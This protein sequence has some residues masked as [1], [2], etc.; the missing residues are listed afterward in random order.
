MSTTIATA[1]LD[2]RA[3]IKEILANFS[4][5]FAG[6][7]ETKTYVVGREPHATKEGY[8]NLGLAQ[9]VIT[10]GTPQNEAATFFLGFDT[11]RVLKTLQ[12]AADDIA[13]TIP[14][15]SEVPFNLELQRQITPFY[16]KRD[17]TPQDAVTNPSSGEVMH[18]W[19]QIVPVS[20]PAEHDP[21]PELTVKNSNLPD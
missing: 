12:L 21:V 19:E 9:R 14:D 18:Y 17:G 11:T 10:P 3:T 5:Q 7:E 20:G 16:D 13:D 2:M 8:T 6:N 15:G 1:G 4:E